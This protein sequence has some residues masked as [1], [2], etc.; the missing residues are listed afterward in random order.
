MPVRVISAVKPSQFTN[1]V[2]KSVCMRFKRLMMKEFN[3]KPNSKVS[4]NNNH[5]I[6]ATT[7]NDDNQQQQTTPS[8]TNKNNYCF[9]SNF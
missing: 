2:L 6:S 8:I 9:P 3:N 7:T 1:V 5:T 4:Y